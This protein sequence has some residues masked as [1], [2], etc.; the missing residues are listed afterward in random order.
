MNL[1]ERQRRLSAVF[2]GEPYPYDTFEAWLR[3]FP[4]E[5]TWTCCCYATTPDG[6]D[7]D[8]WMHCPKS[9]C[10][11]PDHAHTG[12]A[13]LQ[14]HRVNIPKRRRPRE[15]PYSEYPESEIPTP[16]RPFPCGRHEGGY[17]FGEGDA[18]RAAD[19]VIEDWCGPPEYY[20]RRWEGKDRRSIR[21]DSTHTETNVTSLLLDGLTAR[22][23]TFRHP[24]GIERGYVYPQADQH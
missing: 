10:G 7:P 22:Y 12:V 5:N 3:A 24:N 16:G 19:V 23:G 21:V 17:L 11:R 2:T 13:C 15:F 18:A 1:T 8:T 9:A 4:D 6:S 14:P 20:W